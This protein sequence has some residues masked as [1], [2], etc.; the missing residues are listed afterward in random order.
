MNFDQHSANDGRY[1]QN[2]GFISGIPRNPAV[3]A[4]RVCYKDQHAIKIGIA[5][6]LS[7]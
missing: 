1:N 2:H 5:L 7:E 3:A 6:G 4:L